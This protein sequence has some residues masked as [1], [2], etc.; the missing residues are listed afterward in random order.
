MTEEKVT[1]KNFQ[2]KFNEI[3]GSDMPDID[4]LKWAFDFTTRT[5]IEHA[6]SEIELAQA[7][8]DQES[9]IKT[10]IKMETLKFARQMFGTHYLRITGRRAWDE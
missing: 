4:K 8:H 9:K 10:Q 1:S 3:V 7:M 5:V 2:V 6:H